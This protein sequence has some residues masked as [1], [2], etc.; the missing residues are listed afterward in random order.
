MDHRIER[1][2]AD[3]HARL[4]TPVTIAAL[5][6]AASLSASRFAHLFQQEVGT[7][8]A[9]YVHAL[10]MIRARL[11]IE[12]T[13]LSIKEVMAQVGCNDPSHF[14]RD[15]RGFHGLS[16]REW[17]TVGARRTPRGD[18]TEALESATV[19]RIAV[20][21]NERQ[22]RPTK[23]VPRARAPDVPLHQTW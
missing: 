11:L 23:P 14:A 4:A 19:A 2:L 22:K 1:A 20:L 16:P 17:R 18:N 12:R 6:G 21:A 10:R 15:F 5:A 7:S 9:H 8:P 3:I 13:S